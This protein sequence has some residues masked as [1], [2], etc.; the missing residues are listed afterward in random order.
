MTHSIYT[1]I[2]YKKNRSP[3]LSM[4]KRT[5]PHIK[6]KHFPKNAVFHQK[7]KTNQQKHRSP[8]GDCITNNKIM[9]NL[10]RSGTHNN[11]DGPLH[12]ST[13]DLFILARVPILEP[14]PRAKPR[15]RTVARTCV[16]VASRETPGTPGTADR[17]IGFFFLLQTPTP[18]LCVAEFGSS[19]ECGLNVL[20]IIQ[21]LS[22]R[23][24]YGRIYCSTKF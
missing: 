5:P 8:N 7:K 2:F 17:R 18:T 12:S 19:T 10:L 11:N 15:P 21:Y 16:C 14:G 1:H 20:C 24:D 23:V 22:L 4:P 6:P 3:I 9:W 13:A